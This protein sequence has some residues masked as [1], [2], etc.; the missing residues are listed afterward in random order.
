MAGPEASGRKRAREHDASK[1]AGATAAADTAED[2]AAFASRLGRWGGA[3]RCERSARDGE[4]A[5]VA[6]AFTAKGETIVADPPL[7]AVQALSNRGR[8]LA[9]AHCLAP[10]GDDPA[11]HLA[12]AAGR[13]SRRDLV[14]A[15]VESERCGADVQPPGVSP[16]P[17]L[18]PRGATAREG[19]TPCRRARGGCLEVFCGEACRDA[20]RGWHAM[21]CLGSCGEGS[22]MFEFRAHAR[23]THESFLLAADALARALADAGGSDGVAEGEA[24]SADGSRVSGLGSSVLT[25]AKTNSAFPNRDLQANRDA[26][27]RWTRLFASLPAPAGRWWDKDR[28]RV[29]AGEDASARAKSARRAARRA[30]H[31]REQIEDAHQLLFMAWG[32][33]RG[34]RSDPI[35]MPFL[36]FETFER[37]VAA[38]DRSAQPLNLE[39]PGTKYARDVSAAAGDDARACA[40]LRA[41]ARDAENLSAENLADDSDQASSSSEDESTGD[42]SSSD[43]DDDDDEN[44]DDD[45]SSNGDS[46]NG[47]SSPPARRREGTRRGSNPSN[48]PEDVARVSSDDDVLDLVETATASFPRLAALALAPAAALARH[49]C[50]PNSQVEMATEARGRDGESP[51]ACGGLRVSLVAL[52]DVAPG[53]EITVARVPVARPLAERHAELIRAFGGLQK[54]HIASASAEQPRVCACARCVY[55]LCAAEGVPSPLAA[56]E[57]CA[58]ADQASEEGRHEDAERCAREAAE[59]DPDRETGALHKVGVALLGQGRWAEAHEAWAKA[60]ASWSEKQPRDRE[61]F[62]AL[63]AQ[64]AKDRAYARASREYASSSGKPGEVTD[65]DPK[66]A[67]PV[68]SPR[69]LHPSAGIFTSGP[70]DDAAL[71]TPEAC[72]VWIARAEAAAAAR[73]G[74]TT[75]R[76]YAVPTTDLPV[77]EIPSLLPLWN[78]FLARSLGPFLH[79]CF[80]E[81]VRAGGSN[82]RVHDAFV[83][84]YDAGAQ[85]Y[86]PAHV[87]QS[88][89]SVTLALNALG[90]YEGGGTTF[91]D[92]TRVTAR[93]DIGGVV[94]FG[95]DLR[96][97]GAPV[98]RGVRYIVAAFLFTV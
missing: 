85:R 1:T 69:A 20:A 41:A 3:V 34:L 42:S 77:H 71:L 91:P 23:R 70:E 32:H 52:R 61:A 11:R 79:A 88:E 43:D 78:A 95:G 98:T 9:C 63:A 51:P 19:P 30:E 45:D 56:R 25:E 8:F 26:A 57:L 72:A 64:V 40:S 53:E 44:D 84:R 22:P 47:D 50:L 12:L 73:G 27:S 55:E 87:D 81:R 74:W 76:H 24:E 96:H 16:L 92:P 33:A 46:S 75:S 10:A 59:A 21:T 90:E 38:V 4:P 48:L 15:A 17:R 80:P 93:P 29:V 5:L 65:A 66:A 14:A 94:A 13:V 58:L 36:K 82:V 68:R 7:A 83:V 54:T 37:L 2:I 28:A 86:L 35:L 49:S 39:H 89:I 31:L 18:A 6:A 60:Y 67:V 97:A 62:A